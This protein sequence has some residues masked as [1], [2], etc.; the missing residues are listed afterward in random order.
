MQAKDGGVFRSDDAGRTWKHLNDQWK[1]RQR[2][3]YYMAIFALS[4]FLGPLLLG[5]FFDTIGRKPMIS[6]TY[7]GS[8]AIVAALGVL[9]ITVQLT[10]WA[11]MGLVLGCGGLLIDAYLTLLWFEGHGIGRRPLLMLGVL[12][13]I[14]GVQFASLGLL[15]EFLAYQGQQRGYRDALPVRERVGF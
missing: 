12:M 14:T 1:L 9:L 10:T 13:T 6:G 8:A 3:F 4:N 5:R 15:G 11:F 7:L 2:A